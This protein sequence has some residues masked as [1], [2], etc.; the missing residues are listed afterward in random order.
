LEE[1]E[2]EIDIILRVLLTGVLVTMVKE[3]LNR[4]FFLKT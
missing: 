4:I 1:D 2:G 3:S